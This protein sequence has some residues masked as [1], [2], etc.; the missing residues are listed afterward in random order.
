[1]DV[2]N[3]DIVDAVMSYLLYLL[4]TF[5]RD[6]ADTGHHPD[7]LDISQ[8]D[9]QLVVVVYLLVAAAGSSGR[10]IAVGCD[11]GENCLV[12]Y[13][14]VSEWVSDETAQILTSFLMSKN[15]FHGWIFWIM[16]K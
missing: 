3:A 9:S 13:A 7:L 11:A 5:L 14:Q 16:H 8:V 12:N 6:A 15:L 4:C 2:W 10:R 1:M